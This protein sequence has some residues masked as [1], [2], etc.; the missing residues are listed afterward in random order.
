MPSSFDIGALIGTFSGVLKWLITPILALLSLLAA[1][2]GFKRRLLVELRSPG[3]NIDLE[4][5]IKQALDGTG[6]VF[7]PMTLLNKAK[8]MSD[9]LDQ[10]KNGDISNVEATIALGGRV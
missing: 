6:Y 5:K 2:A 1:I 8:T 10:V 3:I 4:P 7:V 9:V